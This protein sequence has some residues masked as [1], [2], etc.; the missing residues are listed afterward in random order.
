MVKA[1]FLDRDGTINEL[2]RGRENPK[3]VCPWYYSEFEFIH[4]VKEAIEIFRSLGFTIHVVT[5]QPDVDDG[6]TTEETMDVIHTLIKTEL[7]VDTIQAARTRGTP[8]YKP[9][10][11]MLDNIINKWNV[12]KNRSWMIGDTW[13]DV[14]AG[15]KAGVKTIYLGNTYSSPEEHSGIEPDFI[16][17]DLLEAALII[18]KEAKND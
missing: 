9:N 1:I 6:Y 10:S 18:N 17:K 14:V 4:G 3:H 8:E 12:S 2:V 16:V 5:N 13:R 11:G 15:N 7:K